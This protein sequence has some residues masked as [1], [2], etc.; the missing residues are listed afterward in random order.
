[1]D[2]YVTLLGRKIFIVLL[3][4]IT[5]WVCLFFIDT[6]GIV[7]EYRQLF[8]NTVIFNEETEI[9]SALPVHFKIPSINVDTIIE[10]VN[11]T[12]EGSVG[13]PKGPDKVAWFALSPIPGEKGN[14]IIAG[15][16]GYKNNKPAVFDNLHKLVKGDKIYI[17]DSEGKITVFIVR[18]KIKYDNQADVPNVFNSNDEKSHLNLI[19][20]IGDWDEKNKT[21]SERLVV[22]ADKE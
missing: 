14:A 19:T 2:T 12:K 1:V 16:S 8:A 10:Y 13:V 18:K 3:I 4:G 21:H 17:E 22:F 20:C 9:K 15:H 5:S 6:K 7:K 11:L